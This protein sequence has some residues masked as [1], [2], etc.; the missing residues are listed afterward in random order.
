[1]ELNTSILQYIDDVK[2]GKFTVEEFTTATLDRIK[3]VD[4]N[5][6]AYLSLNESAI[7][8][9]RIIDKKISGGEKVGVC[10]GFPISIKDNICITGSKTTCASKILEDFVAPYTATVVN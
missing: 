1:M 8:D 9:A 2:S 3:S 7:N 10:Y 5:V 6:H 4:E